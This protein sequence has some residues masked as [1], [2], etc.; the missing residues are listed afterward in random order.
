MGVLGIIIQTEFGLPL[1]HEMFDPTLAKFE[2]IDTSLTSGFI[3]AIN[4]FTKQYEMTFGHIKLHQDTKDIYGVNMIATK[5]GQ[6]LILCFVEPYIYHDVVR[7]KI[8]WI[9][10]RILKHYE[11][12]IQ[13]GKVPAL[14][15]EEKVWIADTLQDLYLKA[16]IAANKETI[17]N[18]LGKL[19]MKYVGVYG[20]SINSFDN[21]I[22]YFSG[23]AEETFKLLLNNLGR[24]SAVI[25]EF[26]AV[27]S[28]ISVPD[29][30]AMRVYAVNSG[31][32]FEIQ[33]I[34]TNLPEKTVSFYYYII[35]DPSLDV[36]P[37]INEVFEILNPFFARSNNKE[38]RN[39]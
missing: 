11:P 10:D 8:G 28:Y 23:I 20:F 22:L 16:M 3:T 15:D 1:Y 13:A 17:S 12:D 33:D 32:K 2:Q 29:Y 24:R 39:E 9:Y 36:W 6:F 37:V 31:V 30:Q 34:M 14:T 38:S 26:E 4:M 19:F 21:S 18:L 27:D 7:E 35:V 25:S 5:M